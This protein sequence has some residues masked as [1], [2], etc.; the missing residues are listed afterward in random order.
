MAASEPRPCPACLGT[1]GPTIGEVRGFALR[2]CGDCGTVFT[3]RLPGPEEVH[4]YGTVHDEGPPRVPDFVLRRLEQTVSG[5][6]PYRR[7][8][9]WLDV[10][11]GAGTLMRAAAARGWQVVGTEVAA[12]A[13]AAGRAAGFDVRQGELD[14]LPLPE[15]GFDVVSA[16]EVLEHVPDPAGL[17]AAAAP[18]MRPGGALYLTTPHGRGLS[19]RLL[20][21]RWSVM[22][23]PEHLQLFSVEGLRRSLVRAGLETRS[24][25]T[26][27]VNPHE[28][29]AALGRGGGQPDRFEDRKETSYRINEALSG[30]RRG[31]LV[32]AVVNGALSTAR[33]GDTIKVVAER[34]AAGHHPS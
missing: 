12:G 11:C 9:S 32:K 28:L 6:E 18:L 7:L 33:L 30:S 5:F 22:T 23:P 10:G 15:G 2:R 1:T 34:Q 14:D 17:L 25:R 21:T 13:I 8:G 4:D 29:R 24:V 20:G 26:H 27:A 31:E 19:A 3:V 16:V